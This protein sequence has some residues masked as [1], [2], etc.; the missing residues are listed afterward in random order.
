MGTGLKGHVLKACLEVVTH[1][2]VKGLKELQVT[3][4]VTVKQLIFLCLTK[5]WGDPPL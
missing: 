3:S 5:I 2:E 4:T 1:T